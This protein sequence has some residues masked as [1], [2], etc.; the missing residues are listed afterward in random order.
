M[1][2]YL[3]N[4]SKELKNYSLSLNKTSILINKPWALLDED[5]EIQK[6]IFKKNKDLLP[7]C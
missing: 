4:I 2:D 3:M 6:L 1:K 7:F 5:N